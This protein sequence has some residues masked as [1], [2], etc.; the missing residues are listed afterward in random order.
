MA[1]VPDFYNPERIGT[2]FYPDK[3]AIAAA[4]HQ[5][6]LQPSAEDARKMHLL[7]IDMQVDFCHKN[8][9]LYVPGAEDDIKRTIEFIYRNAERISWITCTLDSHLPHQIF[10]PNWWV[11][12][13]GRHPEPYTIIQ[14][15]D[16]ATGRWIPVK[17]PEWSV[18]YVHALEEQA[19]KTLTIW[20]YHVLIGSPGYMLDPE[21]WSAV[22][23][24]S[25]ARNTV[26]HWLQKGSIPQ[27]EHYSAI[28]PEID[29]PGHPSAGRNDA[30]LN[31]L[32]V[33]DAVYIAGEAESH[34]VLETVEDI[35]AEFSEMPAQLM[36]MHLLQDCTSPVVHP[37]ID[38]HALAQERFSEFSE[39]GLQLVN[40]VDSIA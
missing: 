31:E 40:S 4:A 33:A 12:E 35:V 38:F 23:W 6:E 9:S 28:E 10:S 7:I 14:A 24:H 29:V 37:Q 18:E 3:E 15:E 11:D 25:L 30:L 36:K 22:T 13:E 1:S 8:G 27:T 5:A 2:L 32:A 39:Q 26:P 17:M 20:P 34:C 19:K 16:V 21:L